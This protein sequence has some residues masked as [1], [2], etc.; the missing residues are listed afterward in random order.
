[1][2]LAEQVKQARKR[3]LMRYFGLTRAQQDFVTK[4]ESAVSA[5]ELAEWLNLT[6]RVSLLSFSNFGSNTPPQ[7]TKVTRALKL[8]KE[9]KPGLTVDGEMQADVAL[10][11]E[12]RD[13]LFPF[14]ALQED[15]NILVFPEL[16]SAN[17]AY[18]LLKQVGD[19]EIVGPILLGMGK[20]VNVVEQGCSVRSVINS[21]ALTAVKA[22]E[23]RG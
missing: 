19:V 9:K 15:A 8:I 23:I 20:P 6:P 17:I 1:M 5:A 4:A 18:K 16:N 10:D 21:V 2:S 3:L 11:R 14:S 22:Q 7:A 12:L 13:R